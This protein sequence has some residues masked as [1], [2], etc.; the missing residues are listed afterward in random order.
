MPEYFSKIRVSNDGTLPRVIWVEPW[1]DDF[2]LLPRE[3]LEAH[4]RSPVGLPSFDIVESDHHTQLYVNV[5]DLNAT[6]EVYLA[7]EI[8]QGGHNRQAAIDAGIRM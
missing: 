4:V 6:Y 8:I 5:P 1:A 2:T 7:G 3:T